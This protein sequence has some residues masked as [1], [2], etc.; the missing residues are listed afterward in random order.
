MNINQNV[1]WSNDT[2]LQI[3]GRALLELGISAAQVV[4]G[5]EDILN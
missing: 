4:I 3:L 1:S 5:T 2:E